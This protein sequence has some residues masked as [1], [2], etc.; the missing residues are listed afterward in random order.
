MEKTE[1]KTVQVLISLGGGLLTNVQ[2]FWS[3]RHAQR[4]WNSSIHEAKRQVD[5]ERL[6]LEDQKEFDQDPFGF[7][8]GGEKE[9]IWEEAAVRQ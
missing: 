2:V 7:A 8:Y 4:Y 6:S 9:L 1:N 5:Y 3:E